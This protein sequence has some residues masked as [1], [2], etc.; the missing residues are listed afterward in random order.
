MIQKSNEEN[1]TWSSKHRK[2]IQRTSKCNRWK[3][4]NIDFYSPKGF[5]VYIEKVDTLVWGRR[6]RCH[7]D[8]WINQSIKSIN[9]SKIKHFDSF[10]RDLQLTRYRCTTLYRA[11]KPLFILKLTYFW[12]VLGCLKKT[13][14]LMFWVYVE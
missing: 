3:N 13:N 12:L 5:S 1:K 9:N 10:Y 8:V 14:F 6:I 11:F 4:E 2:N 7:N